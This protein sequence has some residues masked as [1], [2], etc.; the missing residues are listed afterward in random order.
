MP[1]CPICNAAVWVGERYCATCNNYLPHPEEEDHFCPQYS[2]RV[3]SPTG[4]LPQV[5]GR[6]AGDCWDSLSSTGQGLEALFR[7]PWHFHRHRFGHRGPAL[8]IPLQKKSWTSSTGR[9]AA[10]SGPCKANSCWLPYPPHCRN[11]P[12]GSH[13]PGIRRP[14]R[15]NHPFSPEID[16]ANTI[17]AHVRCQH[18]L[19]GPPGWSL[20]VCTPNR[21]P[22]LPR[23]GGTPGNLRRMGAS[24]GR[25]AQYRRLVQ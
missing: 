1:Q 20:R 19:P 17:A 21:H 10:A 4:N 15:T 12:I 13:G 11:S 18:P 7:G 14:I 24:A 8:G 2:I 3:G 16:D 25:P 9:N 22:Q 6:L 23:R 5:Q